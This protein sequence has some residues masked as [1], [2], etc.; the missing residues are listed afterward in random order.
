MNEVRTVRLPPYNTAI[1][2]SGDTSLKGRDDDIIP[3]GYG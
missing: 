1:Y 2:L 3:T